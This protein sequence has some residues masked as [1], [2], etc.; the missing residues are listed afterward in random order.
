MNSPAN[1][2]WTLSIS[3]SLNNETTDRYVEVVFLST[4][5]IDFMQTPALTAAN[6][7]LA[8]TI[9]LV[10][11]HTSPQF[12]FWK[13]MNWLFVSV[14]WTILNDLGQISPTHYIFDGGVD[15]LP[16]FSR[17]IQYLPTNNIFFNASLF[18]IYSAYLRNTIAPFLNFS[19]TAEILP[20]DN[21]NN[22]LR[23]VERTFLRS[24]SCIERRLKA[25]ISW[26]F[27]V[28]AVVG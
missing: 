25:P 22:H 19:T 6:D 16:N 7:L 26:I 9:A 17:P 2:H 5:E 15:C 13:L 1:D 10:R 18:N 24:Y 3:Y 12:D 4:G 8:P 28:I 21:D 14:Y 23:P 11:S 27:S 20:L